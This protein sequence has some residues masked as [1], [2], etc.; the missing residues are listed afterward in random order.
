MSSSASRRAVVTG[1]ASG[2]GRALAVHLRAEGWRVA[3][4]DRAGATGDL[5]YDVDVTDVAAVTAAVGTAAAEL[6]G[7]DALASCAGVFPNTLAPVHMLDH[8]V[9]DLTLGVNLTGS[10]NVARAALPHL[11]E[12]KGAIVLVSSTAA[13]HSQPGGA[14]YAASKAGVRALARSIALEYAP[15][16]VRACSVSPG[17]MQT[18]MTAKV[19][20]RDDIRAGVEASIPLG[21]VSNP[22]EVAEVIAFLLGTRASFLTGEDVTVDG[23]GGLMAYVAPGDVAGMWSRQERRT[24]RREMPL[25]DRLT[26]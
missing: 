1:T 10:F 7:I 23:G 25:V 17:Y 22:A 3:G 15:L 2:L 11:I 20:S 5:T 8:D 24:G 12:S 16:G 19:L 6:G 14:A 18:A 9:W 13:E 21:R 4:L 26:Q